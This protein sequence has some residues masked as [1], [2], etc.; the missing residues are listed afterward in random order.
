[1][2]N[3]YLLILI[4]TTPTTVDESWLGLKLTEQAVYCWFSQLLKGM[5]LCFFSIVWLNLQRIRLR[6]CK[7]HDNTKKIQVIAH[8]RN[9]PSHLP[10][11]HLLSKSAIEHHQQHPPRYIPTKDSPRPSAITH[12]WTWSKNPFSKSYLGKNQR[13]MVAPEIQECP[14]S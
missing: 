8:H 1:M 12:P 6:M 4:N 3:P 10:T 11:Q 9:T 5:K 7:T 14:K 13:L 2:G